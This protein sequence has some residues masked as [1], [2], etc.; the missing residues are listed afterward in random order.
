MQT[1]PRSDIRGCDEMVGEVPRCLTVK[2]AVHHDTHLVS[3]P[4][5]HIQ[6]MGL[7]HMHSGTHAQPSHLGRGR[8]AFPA[9]SQL[10]MEVKHSCMKLRNV[11]L[12]TLLP[13]MLRLSLT[14]PPTACTSAGARGRCAPSAYGTASKFD[15]AE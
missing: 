11:R 8:Y 6:P 3:D 2:T 1:K 7:S 5:W 9:Q 13:L 15:A 12:F 10:H 14:S 4:L